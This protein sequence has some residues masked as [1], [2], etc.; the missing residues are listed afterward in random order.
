[1]E[2]TRS[3]V[4][5]WTGGATKM[6]EPLYELMKTLILLCG[7]IHTDDVPVKVRDSGRKIKATV[8]PPNLPKE[9]L[10]EILPDRW[11]P[12]VAAEASSWAV[13]AG[14][15][16]PGNEPRLCPGPQPVTPMTR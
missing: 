14:A 2:I 11:S 7:V 12:A 8:R 3:T 5:D 13:A 16:S 9:C 10:E 1:V 4:C 15:P 6:L